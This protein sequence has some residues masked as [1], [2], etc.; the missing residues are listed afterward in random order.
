MANH[1]QDA[2]R[3][4]RIQLEILVDAYGPEEQALGWYTYLEETLAFPFIA[5]CVTERSISPLQVGDEVDIIGMAPEAECRHEMFVL[6][7]WGHG[8]SLAIPLSQLEGRVVDE[9]TAQA[10]GDWQYWGRSGREL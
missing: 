2:E 3:E 7:R 5:R 9:Q 8:R 1:S 6:T 4:Q 10:L